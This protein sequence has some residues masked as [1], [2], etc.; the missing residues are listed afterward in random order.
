MKSNDDLMSFEVSPK[1]QMDLMCFDEPLNSH[2][3]TKPE[4]SILE[5]DSCNPTVATEQL[6]VVENRL[7]DMTRILEQT[8]QDLGQTEADLKKKDGELVQVL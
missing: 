6:T 7:S 5:L 3:P 1:G 8:K 2:I 4:V